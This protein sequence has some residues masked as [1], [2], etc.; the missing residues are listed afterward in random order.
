MV[1]AACCVFSVAA[2]M[3]TPFGLGVHVW[4]VIILWAAWPASYNFGEHY[5]HDHRLSGASNFVADAFGCNPLTNMTEPGTI[6][7][8]AD[9]YIAR[10]ECTWFIT[11]PPLHRAVINFTGSTFSLEAP[12]EGFCSYDF[13]L[14]L[15]DPGVSPIGPRFCGTNSPGVQASVNRFMLVHFHID[16]GVLDTGFTAVVTF[17]PGMPNN[18]VFFF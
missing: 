5:G 13:V 15:T 17:E 14:V 10:Q 11:A 8:T 16:E 7:I 2:S 3:S 12:L 1:F 9:D 4:L 18:A 6:Q